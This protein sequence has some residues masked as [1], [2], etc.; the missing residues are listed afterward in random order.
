MLAI[1]ALVT[2]HLA[3]ER[4]EVCS[5][6]IAGYGLTGSTARLDY[7]KQY[8]EGKPHGKM[9][10]YPV[11]SGNITVPGGEECYEEGDKLMTTQCDIH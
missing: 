10:P 9:V 8:K 4:T 2:K 11:R 1:Q 7:S 3:P 6:T 5:Y